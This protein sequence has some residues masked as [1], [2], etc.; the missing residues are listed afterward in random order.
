[1]YSLISFIFDPV[2]LFISSLILARSSLRKW[3]SRESFI[4]FSVKSDFFSH[5]RLLS[6]ITHNL[7]LIF[8]NDSNNLFSLSS[9]LIFFSNWSLKISCSSLMNFSFSGSLI[10]PF[11]ISRIEILSKSSPTET[12]TRILLIKI[13]SML[14]CYKNV[15]YFNY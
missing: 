10:F 5:N 14:T 2:W 3:T 6:S 11:L 7:A 1:M 8:F 13:Y 4:K 15:Q 9:D 12:S